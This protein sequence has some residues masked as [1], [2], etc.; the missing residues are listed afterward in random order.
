MAAV[1]FLRPCGPL[2]E[3]QPVP[4]LTMRECIT[5][6]RFPGHCQRWSAPRARIRVGEVGY[7]SA[8]AD[9]PCPRA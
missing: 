8:A 2:R 6:M 9:F 5:A 7:F 4:L 1:R 3:L